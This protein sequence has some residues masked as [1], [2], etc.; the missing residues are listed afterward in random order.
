MADTIGLSAIKGGLFTENIFWEDPAGNP[1]D[2]KNY[3]FKMQIRKHRTQP[4]LLELTDFNGRIF[5]SYKEGKI[6]IYI[7]EQEMAI[8]PVGNLLYE[9]EM[10][11]SYGDIFKF[12]R[13]IFTV[14]EEVSR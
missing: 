12:L 3:H 4:V 5:T 13:G 11:D 9:I 6:Q 14:S 1:I 2:I 7:P 10:I 8:L